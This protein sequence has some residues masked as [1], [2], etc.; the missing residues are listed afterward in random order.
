VDALK[1]NL[2]TLVADLQK[3]KPA[4]AKGVYL[5]RVS[6]SSTMGPG[7]LVDHSTLIQTEEAEA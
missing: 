3:L 7:V 5:Q 2:M 1:Q 4:S 6:V